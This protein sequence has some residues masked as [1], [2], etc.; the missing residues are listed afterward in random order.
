MEGKRKKKQ[1]RFV[2]LVAGGAALFFVAL[3]LVAV[4]LLTTDDSRAKRQ[5]IQTVTLLKPPPPPPPVQKPPEP[6][7]KKEEIIEP[8]PEKA[9]PEE[10]KSQSEDDRPAGDQ[11]GLDA[12]GAAGADGFGLVGKK[13][14]RA[15][16][17][18]D[19]GGEQSLLRKYAWYTQILQEEIRNRV[20][21]RLDDGGGIPKG[22]LHAVVRIVMDERGG[23]A[24]FEIVGSS[25]N[26][27]MDD[28]VKETLASARIQ[29][30]PPAGM[31][32]AMK[33]KISSQG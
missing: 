13:G 3:A 11:L 26:H 17:A 4:K 33:L 20:R 18:G 7:V 27:K 22:K 8:E 24:S 29:E 25:G 14:G 9:K 21:K 6:E 5:A 10:S 30:P 12:D 1:G 19:G 32:K 28:A 15:L 2:W 31:P 16:L 23:I